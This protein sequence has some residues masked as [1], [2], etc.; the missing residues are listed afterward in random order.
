MRLLRKG[1]VKDIYELDNGNILFHFSDRV[2]A[3]DVNMATPIPRKGEVLCRFGQFWF[4]TLQTPHHMVRIVE[5]DKM[6]VK[7]LKMVP[8]ECVVRGYFYG[9]FVDRYKG[10]LG[11]GLPLDFKP[12]LAGKLP[13]PIFDP[14]TKSEEHDTPITRQQAIFSGILSEKD[15]DYLEKTSISLYE[16]MSKIVE[17]A[18][19]IIAD[20]KFEFG[21]NEQGDIVLGDSLGP[22]EYRLWLK[23]DHQPGKVQESYDKQLLRDWLAK[24]GFKDKVD[25]LAKEGK[26]PES[27]EVAPEVANE[28]SRRY[29]LAYERIS[30]RKL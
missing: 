3:F 2:S 15:F 27:P 14:T 1:K 6:E 28:L 26:K 24:I 18:G 7:K 22:D 16:K 17:R 5:K 9:S 10:H 25:S 12:I 8:V 29:I 4:D 30:G 21:R 19:F 13:R 23:T 11:K 20:V